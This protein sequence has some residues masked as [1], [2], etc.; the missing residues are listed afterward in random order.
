M[1]EVPESRASALIIGQVYDRSQV[2]W[3]WRGG[4][5]WVKDVVGLVKWRRVSSVV[6]VFCLVWFL[7]GVIG[8]D[9]ACKLV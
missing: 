9:W 4:G 2:C 7:T 1:W 6:R 8:Y 3:W 5:R